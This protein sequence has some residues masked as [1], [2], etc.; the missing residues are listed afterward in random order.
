M[1]MNLNKIKIYS[2][3][4]FK[5]LN[6]LRNIKQELEKSLNKKKVLGTILIANEGINGTISGSQYD[7]NTFILKIKN[8]LKI[9]F[10]QLKISENKFHPF[11]RIKIRIKKEI[12]T[13]G[14]NNIKTEK[15]IGNYIL[16]E[17][18][19]KTI[20]NK[21]T[22]ILDTRNEYEVNIGTFKNAENPKLKSFKEFP[23]FIKNRNLKK[24]Q[25]IAMFCTGG[26]RCEKASSYLID[27]GFKNI[28]QLDGGILNYLEF[29]KNKKKSSWIGECFVFDN[30]VA[31]NSKLDIGTYD[32]CY[33]CR[34]PITEDDKKLKSYKKGISCKYC[35]NNRTEKQK[36]SSLTR[37]K[38]IELAEM[39]NR[40]HNFKKV[41]LDKG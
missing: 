24:T 23:S 25:P 33:G 9:R 20:K 13:M 1:N 36:K 41:F 4:K 22:L 8:I 29:K 31:V 39:S 40:H 19:D 7:L 11:Y 17:E 21:D 16:P 30:R 26:I 3:Y 18:W 32:Q 5:S 6:N 15:R 14:N 10:L 34:H 27:Q 37:Q 28:Y 38:Q 12:V 2:F 35:V